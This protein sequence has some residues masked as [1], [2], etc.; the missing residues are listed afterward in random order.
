MTH[1]TYIQSLVANNNGKTF[2]QILE[3]KVTLGEKI[4]TDNTLYR[5]LENNS[6]KMYAPGSSKISII[7]AIKLEKNADNLEIY[8]GLQGSQQ[9]IYS[10]DKNNPESSDEFLIGL[11]TTNPPFTLE[12][13]TS[14]IEFQ[15]RGQK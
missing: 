14:Q 3:N 7:G 13:V 11:P 15:F 4:L 8:E 1:I 12:T 9:E 2:K 10:N 5:P 6:V